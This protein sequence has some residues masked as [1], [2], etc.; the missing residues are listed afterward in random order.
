[1]YYRLGAARYALVTTDR[2]LILRKAGGAQGPRVGDTKVENGV[3]YRLNQHSR[4]ERVKNAAA[5]GQM[6]LFGGLPTIQDEPS[7]NQQQNQIDSQIQPFPPVLDEDGDVDLYETAVKG[8]EIYENK[9]KSQV[10]HFVLQH[11]QKMD[12]MTLKELESHDYEPEFESYFYD[13][14]ETLGSQIGSAIGIES[15]NN[16]ERD[17]VDACSDSETIDNFFQNCLSELDNHREKQIEARESQIDSVIDENHNDFQSFV[18]EAVENVESLQDW[19]LA[20]ESINKQYENAVQD[21]T[22]KITQLS[23]D[24][25][26]D[27]VNVL[28]EIRDSGLSQYSDDEWDDL[29]ESEDVDPSDIGDEYYDRFIDLANEVDVDGSKEQAILL[30]KK[31]YSDVLQNGR[32]AIMN[33]SG[34]K[35]HIDEFE[36][37]MSDAYNAFVN[38]EN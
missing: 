1:M 12:G 3:T 6:S 2:G 33:A 32:T 17:F 30:Y 28:A 38:F 5:P 19:A 26:G 9:L 37:N 29:D 16:F 25:P 18:D 22:K 15:N 21:L 34:T 4:W 36:E 20:K 11:K 27:A 14:V 10:N 31:H 24:G 7:R 13:N 23:G 8:L 35:A